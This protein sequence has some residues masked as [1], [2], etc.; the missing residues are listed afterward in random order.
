MALQITRSGFAGKDLSYW[1]I[2]K[3]ETAYIDNWETDK[4]QFFRFFI[5]GYE[6]KD[7]RI[8]TSPTG[9]WESA[10]NVEIH[11][12]TITGADFT[13]I[14]S[15]SSGDLRPAAYNYLKTDTTNHSTCVSLGFNISTGTPNLGASVT[16]ISKGFF[17]NALDI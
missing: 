9:E 16:G 6:D 10:H 17:N 5:E 15:S 4:Y 2:A 11:Q 7:Q 1:K 13:N 3:T 8:H 14:M 12:Y